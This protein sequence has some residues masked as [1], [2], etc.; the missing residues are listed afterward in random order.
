MEGV[1]VRTP[2]AADP[3]RIG[4]VIHMNAELQ[5][6]SGLWLNH[7]GLMDLGSQISVILTKMTYLLKLNPT[8][9]PCQ[10]QVH[11][12]ITCCYGMKTLLRYESMILLD[13]F[14][15]TFS[16]SIHAIA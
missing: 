8:G 10:M 9:V 12:K 3:R 14:S 2:I 11:L 13:R 1:T 5:N 6:T 7:S 15:N 4:G 16:T